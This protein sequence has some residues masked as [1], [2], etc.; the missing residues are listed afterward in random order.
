MTGGL[1]GSELAK[2]CEQSHMSVTGCNTMAGTAWNGSD[3]GATNKDMTKT[4]LLASTSQPPYIFAC[5]I[6]QLPSNF[7]PP[8]QLSMC[9]QHLSNL[10]LSPTFSCQSY[11]FLRILGQDSRGGNIMSH[12]T[13]EPLLM[14]FWP[15][16]DPSNQFCHIHMTSE[17]PGTKCPCSNSVIINSQP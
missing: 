15:V 3:E 13:H 10:I 2:I 8:Q 7:Y 6:S 9:P 5:L 14:N 12:N 16:L 17:I 4:R 11:W 1:T